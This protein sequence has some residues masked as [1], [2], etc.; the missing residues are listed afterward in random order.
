MRTQF[1]RLKENKEDTSKGIIQWLLFQ[2]AVMTS[3]M[4]RTLLPL[5]LAPTS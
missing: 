2:P 3:S 4:T 1:E 5:M